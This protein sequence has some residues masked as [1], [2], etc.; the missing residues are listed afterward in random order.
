[1]LALDLLSQLSSVQADTLARATEFVSARASVMAAL[2]AAGFT[3]LVLD[4][5]SLTNLGPLGTPEELKKNPTM[6]GAIRWQFRLTSLGTLIRRDGR[7]KPEV[8]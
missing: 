2:D 3:D 4:M 6:F 8:D 1:M 7:R 5:A